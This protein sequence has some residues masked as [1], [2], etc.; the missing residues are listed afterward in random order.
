MTTVA[1][2][3]QPR[4]LGDFVPGAGLVHDAAVVAGGAT[5]VAAAAQFSIQTSLSPV[6]FTGQTFAVLLTAGV[7]GSV[8]G[9][10]SM[11]VYLV[12]GACGAPWFAGGTSGVLSSF[13]Y[14]VGF[15]AA[16]IVVGWLAERGATASPLGTA[17]AM[18]T[19]NVVTYAVGATWLKWAIPL[20]WA[21][22]VSKG[23]LP[24]L[25]SDALKIALAA[26]LLPLAWRLVR[27]RP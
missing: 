23:V 6:P 10:L 20:D 11:L 22:A 13:G 19:G 8:R 4:V 7:L 21:T 18:V 17:A 12:A 3:Q 24:F 9:G 25:G 14:I 2:A 15:I 1:T 27:R 5:F 26:G 16:A